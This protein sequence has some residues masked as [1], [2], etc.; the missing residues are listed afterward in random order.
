VLLLTGCIF[1]R[2]K[3]RV[4]TYDN[5]KHDGNWYYWLENGNDFNLRTRSKE[6]TRAG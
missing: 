2:K 5:K 1:N 4:A 6:T 3:A